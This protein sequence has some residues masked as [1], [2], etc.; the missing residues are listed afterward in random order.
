M[1]SN[2]FVIYPAGYPMRD[3]IAQQ[4]WD[5]FDVQGR[6]APEYDLM[7]WDQEIHP[8][9]ARRKVTSAERAGQPRY[10]L[11]TT[12]ELHSLTPSTPISSESIVAENET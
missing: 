10:P 2:P 9:T 12:S 6:P 1:K 7:Y 4:E 11:D 8:I 5:W 3:P